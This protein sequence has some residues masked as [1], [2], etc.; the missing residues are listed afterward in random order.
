[1][2]ITEQDVMNLHRMCDFLQADTRERK[3]VISGSWFYIYSNDISLISDISHLPWLDQRKMR[4]SEVH[5]QGQPGTI[6]LRRPRHQFRSYFRSIV[7][8]D[9]RR[10]NLARLLGQQEHIRLSPGL[11]YWIGQNRWS[12]T[13]DYHFIDHDDASIKPGRRDTQQSNP[14]AHQR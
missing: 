4:V 5:L 12:R 3:L 11:E 2:D 9:R 14:Q 1:M 8:D 6:A 10:D 7:L 13:L